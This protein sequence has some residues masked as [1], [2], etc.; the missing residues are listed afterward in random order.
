MRTFSLFVLSII[1]LTALLLIIAPGS[2]TIGAAMQ[3][4]TPTGEPGPD[5]GPNIQMPLL[6]NEDIAV[7][8]INSLDVRFY[9]ED[10]VLHD[11]A[12]LESYEGPDAIDEA[13]A[14]LFRD[15]Y[16]NIH[17]Q[18]I[19]VIA[20]DN[21]P[22][23]ME[24]HACVAGLDQCTTTYVP[25]VWIFDIRERQIVEARLYYNP[26]LFPADDDDAG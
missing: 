20:V 23:V 5:Q 6:Q 22:V 17:F 19:K 11:L 9:A 26:A 15:R 8:A 4:P 14:A 10:A 1:G 7:G 13:L 21:A 12:T 18:R 16:P 24:L 2:A 3:N 25:L